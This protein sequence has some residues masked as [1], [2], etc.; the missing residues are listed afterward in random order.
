[1]SPPR[2]APFRLPA[3]NPPIASPIERAP[4]MTPETRPLARVL[5]IEDRAFADGYAQGKRGGKISRDRK[6]L[7][8]FGE[9]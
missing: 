3:R 5:V 4:G 8:S 2:P 1:M 6:S 9:E 7:G